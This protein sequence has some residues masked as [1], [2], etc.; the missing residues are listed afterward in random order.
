MTTP[1]RQ[2]GATALPGR[3]IILLLAAGVLVLAGWSLSRGHIITA[4]LLACFACGL[5]H[6]AVVPGKV[7]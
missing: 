1:Q 5:G 3:G 7:G 6:S 4:G 2:R